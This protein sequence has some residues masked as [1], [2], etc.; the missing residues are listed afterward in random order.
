MCRTKSM[1]VCKQS[2]KSLFCNL[3]PGYKLISIRSFFLF[4]SNLIL[5][6]FNKQRIIKET[7]SWFGKNTINS[8]RNILPKVKSDCDILSF[9]YYFL[10]LPGCQ[11]SSTT[12]LKSLVPCPA[13]NGAHFLPLK[14]PTN[15]LPRSR[16][17]ENWERQWESRM[18]QK[19]S[20]WAAQSQRV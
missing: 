3:T 20:C 14:P 17:W 18:E 7:I 4:F 5:Y 2:R 11:Q 10:P 13:Q 16:R 6:L 19:I 15:G 9:E 8:H 1:K 12:R